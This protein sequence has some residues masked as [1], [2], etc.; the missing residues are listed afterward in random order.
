MAPWPRVYIYEFSSEESMD[1]LYAGY[2]SKGTALGLD[3]R[4]RTPT[5]DMAVRN[6]QSEAAFSNLLLSSPQRTHDPHKADLF[7]IPAMLVLGFFR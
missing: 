2:T 1:I 3:E 6:S 4:D 7:Y 5:A